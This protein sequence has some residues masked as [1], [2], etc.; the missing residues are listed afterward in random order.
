MGESCF[1]RMQDVHMSY[2]SSIYNATT[3]K[4]E[5]FARLHFERKKPLLKDITAIDGLTLDIK[6]GERVGIIGHNGAGKSTLLKTIA[7]IYPI[8]SGILHV[9]GKI[10]ALFDLSLGFDLESTGRENI[11]YRGLLLGAMPEEIQNRVEEIVAFADIGEFIDFPVKSYSSGMLVR[12]AFAVS[13]WLPG[14]LLLLDEIIAAGDAQFQLKARQRILDLIDEAKIMVFVSHDMETV[15]SV[16][17]RVVWLSKGKLVE[18]GAPDLVVREY[19]S[20]M[21]KGEAT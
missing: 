15:R 14:E 5:I 2:P 9:K 13:T 18:D 10:R 12:L 3:L 7:G 11:L 8:E 16:C 19:L 21:N 17:N 20:S 1:I 6:E 4:Q